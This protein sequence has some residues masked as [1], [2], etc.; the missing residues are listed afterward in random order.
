MTFE[1]RKKNCSDWE[2]DY[3]VVAPQCDNLGY[4]YADFGRDPGKCFLCN[5]PTR[6]TTDYWI[7]YG[8]KHQQKMMKT[9]KALAWMAEQKERVT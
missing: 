4:C 3:I 5:K 7:E 1:E 6:I 2:E 9:D 8:L